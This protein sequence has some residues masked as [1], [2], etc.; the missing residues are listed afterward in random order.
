MAATGAAAAY[1]S[2]IANG[3]G[4]SSVADGATSVPLTGQVVAGTT[5][6][7]SAASATAK[8]GKDAAFKLDSGFQTIWTAAAAGVAVVA[9]ALVVL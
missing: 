2:R 5:P 6:G 1:S 4:A 7:S 9:G 3:Q 8:G